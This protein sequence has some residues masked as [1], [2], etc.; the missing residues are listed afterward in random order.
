MP[1]FSRKMDYRKIYCNSLFRRNCF[2]RIPIFLFF[3][4]ISA[5]CTN[6]A[7]PS[8]GN[9]R[10]RSVVVSEVK[11]LDLSS[12]RSVS[13]P[14]I[15]YKRI[16]ITART[17]G[18]VMKLFYEEGDRVREGE[19]LASLDTRRQNAQLRN[20][21]SALEDSKRNYLRTSQLYE[22]N[23][24]SESEYER[25]KRELEKAESEVEFWRAEAELGD[26][27]AP[28]SAVVSDKLVEV[29][30]TVSVNERLFTIEDH[31]LLVLRPG[32]SE[33]D[34]A[35]LSEGQELEIQFD[36]FREELFTGSIRRIFPAADRITRLFTVEV[37]IDQADT[38]RIIRPG[39]LARVHFVTDQ[40]V[41][42]LAVPNEALSSLEG[43]DLVYV[44]NDNQQLE[45]RK[46]EKGTERDGWVE[47]TGGLQEGENVVAGN[48]DALNDG[49]D[50]N[51]A[52]K[53]RRYGF[54]E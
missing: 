52:G 23:V 31:D 38:D 34:V 25:A 30:T 15:A 43:E 5:S 3:I 46:V 7:G 49:M 24:I 44:V 45:S 16:Y 47:I 37:E 42:V 32:V 2:L 54:R 53:F 12:V 19:L 21:E 27:Y 35:F 28:I 40:R 11:R 8:D 6:T 50:V 9:D 41:D 14:V 17:G 26:I 10:L 33:L 48:L 4:I 1:N 36:V 51:V 29:G 22:N 18:Q 39:Y 20:A 13:A